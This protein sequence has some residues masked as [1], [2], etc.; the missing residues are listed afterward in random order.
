MRQSSH[1][2]GMRSW[3][4][5]GTIAL[6]MVA[7]VSGKAPAAP[8]GCITTMP[9]RYAFPSAVALAYRGTLPVAV[10]SEGPAIRNLTVGLYTFQGDQLAFGHARSR[11]TTTQ[12]VA[13]RL[14]FGFL[15]PGQYT[16]VI[17]GEPNAS[18]SCGS[19]HLFHV[20]RFQSCASRLPVTLSHLPGGAAAAYG[21]TL[22]VNADTNYVLRNVA[23]TLTTFDGTI[24][25]RVSERLMF[26]ETAINFGVSGGV[27]PGGYTIT[28]SGRVP[29]QP[30]R[31]GA[32]SASA[33]MRFR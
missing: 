15:N 7:A 5:V 6:A 14:R 31:C 21:N 25:D 20:V 16:L 12:T 24:V 11:L 13:M 9:V 29:G 17:D 1:L 4:G 32:A 22:T 23:A 26:G 10:T 30:Q 27:V 3:L 19:K 28:L 33:A 2:D 8:A 18:P